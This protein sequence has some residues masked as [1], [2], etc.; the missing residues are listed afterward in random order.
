MK[1]TIW[2]GS[3]LSI[4]S[5]RAQYSAES[6]KN[7][8]AII[9]VVSGT[10]VKCITG[11]EEEAG[12]FFTEDIAEDLLSIASMHPIREDIVYALLKKRNADRSVL[13]ELIGQNKIIEFTYEGRK[14]YR[15][16]IRT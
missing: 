5:Y 6:L 1:S 2:T 13:A 9:W 14:F 12:F 16:N 8:V 4:R 3:C 15:K 7:A 11:V 10:D